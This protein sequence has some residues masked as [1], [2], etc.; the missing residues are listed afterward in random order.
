MLCQKFKF[1]F[2]SLHTFRRFS[3]S[4]SCCIYFLFFAFLC[5]FLFIYFISRV[6]RALTSGV[7]LPTC[8]CIRST[9]DVPVVVV[10][11]HSVCCCCCCWMR[12]FACPSRLAGIS[13][14]HKSFLFFPSVPFFLSLLLS[15]SLSF[16]F[17]IFC[18]FSIKDA[19]AGAGRVQA[20]APLR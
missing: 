20:F 14:Q 16:C 17:R 13:G 6:P 12:N 18:V 4:A 8:R 5:I 19:E 1:K 11:S 7:L 9:V 2:S 15:L 10:V 3:A